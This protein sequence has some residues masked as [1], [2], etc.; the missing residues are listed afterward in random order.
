MTAESRFGLIVQQQIVHA[1]V[2]QEHISCRKL[3]LVH[4]NH[5]DLLVQRGELVEIHLSLHSVEASERLLELM[6]LKAPPE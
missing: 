3:S 6:L 2:G 4:L 1:E 5:H